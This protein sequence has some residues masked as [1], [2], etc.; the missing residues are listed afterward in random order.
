M[1]T[2]RSFL[3]RLRSDGG[4]EM[5]L[6]EILLQ[7]RLATTQQLARATGALDRSTLRC[8]QRLEDHHLVRHDRLGRRAGTAPQHWWV[9]PAGA[10]LAASTARGVTGTWAASEVPHALAITELWV[11]M[12]TASETGGPRLLEWRTDRDGWLR[13]ERPHGGT[14]Q[15]T[16]DAMF[17]VDL[18]GGLTGCAIA[19]IDMGT[20]TQ[21]QLR[22]KA[23]RYLLYAA[24][25]GWRGVLPHCPPMLLFTTSRVRAE[26]FMRPAAKLTDTARRRAGTVKPFTI[27]GRTYYPAVMHIAATGTVRTPATAL[28]DA[29][30]LHGDIADE[31]ATLTGLLTQIATA[32][33][34]QDTDVREQ[35]AD[36]AAADRYYAVRDAL[37]AISRLDEQDAAIT[38]HLGG[39]AGVLREYPDVAE[40]LVAWHT[41]P[42][43][44]TA[45]TAAL[46]ELLSAEHARIWTAQATQLATAIEHDPQQASLAAAA[47]ELS[48]GNILTESQAT[49]LTTT[50]GPAIGE[51][52]KQLLQAHEEQRALHVEATLRNMGVLRRHRADREAIAAAYDDE[53]L[54]ICAGCSLRYPHER[55]PAPCS[56]CHS[57]LISHTSRH[58]ARTTADHWHVIRARLGAQT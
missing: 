38:S 48:A 41:T 28:R 20:M 36:K 47:R 13:W 46:R 22:V 58:Q 34:D 24:E 42:G 11:S 53:H 2:G 26:N 40:A 7:Q 51:V 27:L 15:L 50:G 1:P 55:E 57:E 6:L 33:H 9:T 8:L 19:E 16:P 12:L 32:Q 37:S 29:V 43:P 3:T 44:G 14:G 52:Q 31:P 35:A 21:T 54:L 17:T 18:G 23:E 30:W 45:E 39:P 49:V 25:R 5:R 56:T 4:P 10:R